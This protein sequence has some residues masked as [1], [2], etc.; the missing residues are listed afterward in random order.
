MPSKLE[1][2]CLLPAFGMT[3]LVLGHIAL[4]VF[5]MPIMGIPIAALG[6]LFGLIGIGMRLFTTATS[7][8]WSLAG[9][10]VCG[11]ALTVDVGIAYAPKDY[12]QQ[13]CAPQMWQIAPG[14]PAPPAPA[15]PAK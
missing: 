12:V 6:L 11:L 10:A 14:N 5:S 3:S 9:I 8:R 13:R 7:L 2:P 4:L 15:R 1:P